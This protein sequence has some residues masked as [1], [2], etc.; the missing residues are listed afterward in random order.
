M[1]EYGHTRQSEMLGPSYLLV[2]GIPSLSKVLYSK[3]YRKKYGCKWA[4][5]FNAFPESWADKLGGV[6][7][8]AKT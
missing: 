1:H 5:Y 4:N 7:N 8:A 6:K 3:W 2:V